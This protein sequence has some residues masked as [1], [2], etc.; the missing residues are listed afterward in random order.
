MAKER[1]QPRNQRV[2]ELYTLHNLT[3]Q[4]IAD[5]EGISNQRVSQI[6]TEVRATLPEESRE[7]T[8]ARRRAQIDAVISG[9]L[10]HARQG[11]KDATL[12]LVKLW[13]RESRYLG[14]D[15]PTKLEHS[16]G[17]RYEI[18]GLDD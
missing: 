12:S 7:E 11:D 17:V 1:T 10:P 3:Q 13:E 4:Q 15:S 2:W 6:L 18:A 16:G 8:V 14:L 9:H 5:R